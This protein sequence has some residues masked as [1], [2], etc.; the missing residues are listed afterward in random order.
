M[1]DI[2]FKRANEI[3]SVMLETCDGPYKAQWL[4]YQS[5]LKAMMNKI[6]SETQGAIKAVAKNP[7]VVINEDLIRIFS[8][9]AHE[10]KALIEALA[11]IPDDSTVANKQ[12]LLEVLQ[13]MQRHL[14]CFIEYPT[15][16]KQN[17]NEGTVYRLCTILGGVYIRVKQ[18]FDPFMGGTIDDAGTFTPSE[19]ICSGLVT[20]WAQEC[21]EHGTP[22]YPNLGIDAVIQQQDDQGNILRDKAAPV[23]EA[24]A[25]DVESVITI[26]SSIA[27]TDYQP[28]YIAII[29]EDSGHALGI[30]R[31]ADGT[32]EFYDPNYGY[33]F[34]NNDQAMGQWLDLFL[35]TYYKNSFCNKEL[36]LMRFKDPAKVLDNY[37]PSTFTYERAMTT[38]SPWSSESTLRLGFNQFIK[39]YT[40]RQ[41]NNFINE[42]TT[43]DRIAYFQMQYAKNIV[44][45]CYEYEI[46]FSDA[47][48]RR[49]FQLESQE[50]QRG[51]EPSEKKE[52]RELRRKPNLQVFKES[53]VDLMNQ[54]KADKEKIDPNESMLSNLDLILSEIN[55]Q[56]LKAKDQPQKS[57]DAFFLL[58]Q[59]Q[60]YTDS[61]RAKEMSLARELAEAQEQ[62]NP[63]SDMIDALSTNIYIAKTMLK[64]T[65]QSDDIKR[66]YAIVDPRKS[67][68]GDRAAVMEHIK[69]TFDLT[70][71]IDEQIEQIATDELNALHS[72]YVHALARQEQISTLMPS[73][74]QSFAQ[75]AE[76]AD[77]QHESRVIE[78][79]LSTL[80]A[81]LKQC[82]APEPVDIKSIQTSLGEYL[83]SDVARRTE[84][85]A[86]MLDKDD[87]QLQTIFDVLLGDR[88]I[89]NSLLA[90]TLEHYTQNRFQYDQERVEMNFS[91]LNTERLR[92]RDKI[93]YMLSGET[94]YDLTEIINDI[95]AIF[96]NVVNEN[97][98]YHDAAEHSKLAELLKLQNNTFSLHFDRLNKLLKNEYKTLFKHHE[99]LSHY[100]DAEHHEE[101]V[102]IEYYHYLLIEIKI[103]LNRLQDIYSKALL[104]K[105]SG[106]VC[107]EAMNKL[108]G[109]SSNTTEDHDIIL[110]MHNKIEKRP[111]LIKMQAKAR[112]AADSIANTLAKIVSH[113]QYIRSENINAL[114]EITHEF[115]GCR[116]FKA[117]CENLAIE[118]MD[119][120]IQE[121][122]NL[123]R[124]DQQP[125][126]LLE[127]ALNE[128]PYQI[129]MVR[130]NQSLPQL[131]SG[132]SAHLNAND[133]EF[134]E[135][136]KLRCL[137]TITAVVSSL[138]E[139][140]EKLKPNHPFINNL[141]LQ[142]NDHCAALA[143]YAVQI[144]NNMISNLADAFPNYIN[145]LVSAEIIVDGKLVHNCTDVVRAALQTMANRLTDES[146]MKKAPLIKFP[147]SLPKSKKRPKQPVL[148]RPAVNG[149]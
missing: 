111:A 68:Q 31:R 15:T 40:I 148:T 21:I 130:T 10:V 49:Q 74:V 118:R 18:S 11:A 138:K 1:K 78:Q 123:L 52:L 136:L 12:E 83:R 75:A 60:E 117:D 96:G 104:G 139:I 59:I 142:I 51:L 91:L 107:I 121:L 14:E 37:Y 113:Y 58:K 97:G 24:Y 85:N 61:I 125:I 4:S 119:V 20:Q 131:I 76:K 35:N 98:D 63:D 108:V 124:K 95:N 146:R 87:N 67:F 81:Q 65:R 66:L 34:F 16:F 23:S 50:K 13:H 145:G 64:A 137:A 36:V 3:L 128:F 79:Q 144:Q 114:D 47:K 133:P 147:F 70:T 132:L 57:G 102:L 82:L 77:L 109:M 105:V 46:P 32:V 71:P 99:A 41:F 135:I 42:D 80:E 88:E 9:G 120:K 90:K 141:N 93:I 29:E 30:R 140:K 116:I 22:Q 62:S 127:R 89:P 8:E 44:R 94:E 43:A 28:H 112:K 39:E 143:I 86:D 106:K 17:M 84:S 27:P 26:L 115:K 33:F 103:L 122:C 55:A 6:V 54:Y 100:L 73:A 7:R 110:A 53:V 2:N 72:Q 149:F 25:V 129:S 5:K 45:M 56:F 134:A 69:R 48:M 38:Y 19:G 92:L 101:Q 126:A